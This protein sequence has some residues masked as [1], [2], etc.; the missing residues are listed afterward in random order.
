MLQLNK[1]CAGQRKRHTSSMLEHNTLAP[2]TGASKRQMSTLENASPSFA[3]KEDS[4]LLAD[5]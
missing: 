3:V 4:V 2:P 1:I 5:G